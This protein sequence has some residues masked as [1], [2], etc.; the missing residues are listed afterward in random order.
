MSPEP[1]RIELYDATLR[2][3]MGGGG[4][5][6][7]AAEKLRVVHALDELGVHLIEAGFPSSN[8]K[9]RAL[10]EL[11]AGESLRSAEIVAFGMTR[12]RDAAAGQDEGLRVLAECFAPVCTLVGKASVLHVEKVVRVSREENL[13]MIAD[14]IAFLVGAGKRVLL[15]AEHFFDGFQLD[16]SYALDCLRVAAEAGAE[17]LVLCD[18]NGGSLPPF[19]KTA[20]AV[21]TE[22]LPGVRLGIHTHDDSGCGVANALAAVEA[23]ATQVQG[24]VNGIGERTGNANLITLIADLQ[25]KM[26]VRVLPEERLARLTETAHFVDELLNRSPDAA[27]PYVG[28]HAF[29]HKAGLHAAGVQADAQTFEHIDPALVGNDRDV[30]VSELSGRGT[31]LEKARQAGIA[32]DDRL[33]QRV[34]ERVKELEHEGFQF[35]AADGSFELLLRKEAGEYEPL[36]RLESWRVIVERHAGGRASTEATIKIWLGGERFVRTAEGNGPV[37]ALD[38]ALREAIGEIHPHL[39]DIELVNFKVRILDETKGT[40]AVTRVLIDASD[41]HQTWGSIG[42]AE[43]LIAASWDALVDSLEFGMQGRRRAGATPVPQG[44]PALGSGA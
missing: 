35:E 5:T 10:F 37:N 22:A 13:A 1:P 3:G 44:G 14:S 20:F 27:Q 42:V 34:V 33:A 32:V 36:F 18:T 6:L 4:M 12:R 8:P 39:K 23:G 25:L 19:I 30:I 40:G 15:D 2:D 26:G 17:R 9:E 24:T 21:V 16:A 7:T 11:L 29:A 28:K 31:V 38:R 43:N 41:K